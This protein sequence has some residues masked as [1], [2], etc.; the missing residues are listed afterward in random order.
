[1]TTPK[2]YYRVLRFFL[3]LK[4][5]GLCLMFGSSVHADDSN[6]KI[7]SKLPQFQLNDLKGTEFSSPQFVGKPTVIFF[8]GVECPIVKLYM[9]DFPKQPEDPAYQ[10]L[11]WVGINSNRQDSLERIQ[12]FARETDLEKLPVILLKD[13]A[14]RVAD[15]LDAKRTP[16]VYLFDAGGKLVYRGA[17]DDRYHYGQQ[18]A[19]P[20]SRFL[21]DAIESLLQQQ[22]IATET[23][24]A[25]GCLIGRV[26]QPQADFPITYSNQISRIF[27]QRCI[28]CHRDGEIA[29][30][31]MEDY[32]D[33]VG[34][35]EMI[36]EVTQQRRMPP[37]H[38]NP[39]YGHFANDASLNED[40]M[41]MI[42]QWV[43]AG[44]PLGDPDQLP[45]PVEFPTDWQ[46]G[47]PDAIIPMAEVPFEVPATGVIPYKYFVVD[48]GFTEDK[49]VSA[50]ECRI[51]N[52]SVVHHIIVAIHQ[53]GRQETHGVQSQ[54]ITA[55]APGAKPMV[56]PEGYA[57][58]IPAGSKLVFQMHYTPDGTPQTDLSSVGF[59]FVDRSTVKKVVGTQEAVNRRFAIP[60]HAD[61]HQVT[62]RFRFDQD[63]LILSLF[64]HMHLRGK[65]FRYT[66]KYP[67]GSEEIL[68]DIP[69]YDFNWQ[70]SYEYEQPK[71][72][73]A[74]T[75]LVCVAHFDN[76]ANN[77]ANPDPT[78]TVRWGDQTWEEMMIGYFNMALADQDLSVELTEISTQAS[79]D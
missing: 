69:Q 64:P 15:L 50:A 55:T 35:A 14:N 21:V 37:W 59:K 61:N 32:D 65:S 54:W 46:I 67:D 3:C 70:N 40:E 71:R 41:L 76:S 20:Q 44:A 45:E 63:S 22:P 77:F 58:L 4:A 5:S 31:S 11:N 73:P 25:V 29:P 9:A 43:A 17:V 39:D 8:F 2:T 56:L 18:R 72:V 10:D 28:S 47:Q 30:F 1:M 12:K 74:G 53:K 6:F 23:T 75:V 7:G 51:G 52:R 42:Q 62:S 19:E 57:K 78:Q 34:W 13:P 26:L 33:V 27:Q 49:W 36:Q 66:A 38:A 68:L 24:E 79:N 48:P 60:P 16:E